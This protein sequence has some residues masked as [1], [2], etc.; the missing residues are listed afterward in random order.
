M[1]P[2]STESQNTSCRNPTG[3]N[4]AAN[5]STADAGTL[6]TQRAV[7]LP[8][9]VGER[10]RLSRHPASD[11]LAPWIDYHWIVEWDLPPGDE[12]VQHVMPY[13]N[14]NLAFEMGQSALHGPPRGLFTRVLAGRGKVHGV[15]FKCGGLR[16]W[17]DRPMASLHDRVASPLPC[18]PRGADLARIE[19]DVLHD[20]DHAQAVVRVERLLVSQRPFADPMI[21]R[22]DDAVAIVQDDSSITRATAL[23]D[24]LGMSER[25]LQRC[26]SNYLGVTPK[27]IVQR[28]RVHDALQSLAVDAAT[29][30]ADLAYR[31]G[32][33]DQAH[34]ARCFRQH[35]G[36][37]PQ[38]YRQALHA[39]TTAGAAAASSRGHRSAPTRAT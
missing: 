38:Q 23:Q 31:L 25:A 35:T 34:F 18:L 29:P 11:L 30:L 20:T 10:L 13:P 4:A 1:A 32:F 33:F 27:W 24:L 19:Q 39:A 5:Q 6:L 26:A 37:S 28:A 15:R 16:P 12:H 2:S 17:I 22:L 8:Q 36:R 7:L 21:A 3:R 9:L 14:A